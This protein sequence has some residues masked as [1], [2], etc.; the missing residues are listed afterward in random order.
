MAKFARVVM[1]GE[2]IRWF[3]YPVQR[4]LAVFILG[5]KLQGGVMPD[6][7]AQVW[8]PWDEIRCVFQIETD[9]PQVAFMHPAGSA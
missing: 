9:Q 4:D 2:P 3:D 6:G 1:K 7:L 5:T 8:I